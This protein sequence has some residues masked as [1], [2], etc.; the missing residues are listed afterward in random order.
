MS[1]FFVL[2]GNHG[3]DKMSALRLGHKYD[4]KQDKGRQYIG[5]EM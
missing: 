5:I 1:V 2:L 4:E 3:R